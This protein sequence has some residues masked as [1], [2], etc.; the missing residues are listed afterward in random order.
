MI[1]GWGKY[2]LYCHL[3]ELNSLACI[4]SWPL[5]FYKDADFSP[6][7]FPVRL[8]HYWVGKKK[9]RKAFCLIVHFHYLLIHDLL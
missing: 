3:R 7:C 1:Y 8:V 6:F 4:E 2:W 9:V 5:V